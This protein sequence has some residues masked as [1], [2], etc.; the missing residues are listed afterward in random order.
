VA[1]GTR[2]GGGGVKRGERERYSATKKSF[3]GWCLTGKK[4]VQ[5]AEG[6]IIL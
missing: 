1:G 6:N 4:S 5:E 2:L 3:P